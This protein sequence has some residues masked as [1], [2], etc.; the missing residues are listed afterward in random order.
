MIPTGIKIKL[1]S[2]WEANIRPRSGLAINEGITV[3]NTPGTIDSGY[4]G[5]LSVIL[6]NHGNTPYEIEDGDRIA[7][8][9]FQRI[10]RLD[11]SQ[12]L[13]KPNE[14][15][16]NNTPEKRGNKGFGSTGKQYKSKID[17]FNEELNN[18]IS[19]TNKSY[20]TPTQRIL[21]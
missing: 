19:R 6:I 4:E 1:P 3:L 8:I 9:I 12:Y 11:I 21:E 17:S 18:E 20:Y 16:N 14:Y 13:E 7:Q 5:E 2:F 15:Y 10:P